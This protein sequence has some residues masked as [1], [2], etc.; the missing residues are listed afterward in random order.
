MAFSAVP[1]A[2]RP[3]SAQF[4][5]A[6]VVALELAQV[7]V[8]LG[9]RRAAA[10]RHRVARVP[11]PAA[12]LS[13]SSTKIC[14]TSPPTL[15]TTSASSCA[16]IGAVPEYTAT[17]GA[18]LSGWTSTGTEASAAASSLSLALP[19]LQPDA[20]ATHSAAASASQRGVGRSA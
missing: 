7:R 8:G 4:E 10:G 5:L 17:I 19:L 2:T 13:P 16:S 1:L 11:G 18:R 9:E 20:S 12:T 6:L 3:F 14:R 15:A